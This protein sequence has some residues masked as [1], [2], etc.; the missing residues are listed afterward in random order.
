[1]Q[2]TRQVAL[3]QPTVG[4]EELDAIREVFASGWLSGAGPDVRGVRGAS[5]RPLTGTAH[6]LATAN[7]GSA[8]HLA[9]QVLGAGPGTR[10]SSPTTPS[11]R[12]ATP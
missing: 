12:P 7:C 2:S 4:E 6:A 3:G 11:P 10:S 9:L 5:S 8:L 1:M